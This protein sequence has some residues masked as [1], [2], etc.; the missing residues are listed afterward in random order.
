[1]LAGPAGEQAKAWSLRLPPPRHEDLRD[2]RVGLW[3]DDP[4]AEVATEVG[5][6]L[7]AAADSLARAGVRVSDA[8]PALDLAE[9]RRLYMS[10]MQPASH[11]AWLDHDRA[12]TAMRAVW[13]D[14]FGEFDVLLCP[15][16]PTAA[17]PHDRQGTIADRILL[18]NGRPRTHLEA[19]TWTVIVSAAYLPST[20]VPAGFTPG[21]LPV[22]AQLVGPYL[23]DR[24]PLF[25]GAGLASLTCGYV[26][27]PAALPP[28][29]GSR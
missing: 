13:A 9:A 28:D 21:G 15:V 27:P 1:V 12:R 22:G 10:L 3:L 16:F 26:V 6:V 4:A 8:H 7:S 29:G 5:D 19:T 23:E 18:V 24:T 20:V 11:D 14:W 17:F 25:A 2:Y